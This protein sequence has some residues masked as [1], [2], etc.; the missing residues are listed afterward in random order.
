MAATLNVWGHIMLHD[1]DD[2]RNWAINDYL[3]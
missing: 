3:L 2:I 1:D